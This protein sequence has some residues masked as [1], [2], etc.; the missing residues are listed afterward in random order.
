MNIKSLLGTAAL[1]F[2][3]SAPVSAAPIELDFSFAAI[4][5]TFFGLD[6]AD[7]V[8]S[9]SSVAFNGGFDSY[10]FDTSGS[11]SNQFTFLAGSLTDMAFLHVDPVVGSGGIAQ[12]TN[13]VCLFDNC[14]TT[15]QTI[16]FGAFFD[17]PGSIPSFAQRTVSSVPLPAGGV[18][19][20]SA[21]LALAGFSRRKGGD[22]ACC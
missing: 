21:V 7:G 13:F 15:E 6:N 2:A 3:L 4:S 20:A 17:V 8:S 14:T 19:L 16:P 11:V 22:S 18:L 10:S 9:A 1:A 5:G 12:L